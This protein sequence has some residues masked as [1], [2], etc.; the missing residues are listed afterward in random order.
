MIYLIPENVTTVIDIYK[1]IIK[2]EFWN[3]F[4]KISIYILNII[5]L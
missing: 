5:F 3:L 2:I 4:S 1:I